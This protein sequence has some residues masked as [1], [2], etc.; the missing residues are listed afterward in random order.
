MTENAFIRQTIALTV[1][2]LKHWYR[3]KMQIFM[4]LIQPLIWLGLFGTMMSGTIG[5]VIPDFF[6]FLALGMVV[7]TALTTAMSSGMSLVWDRRFG[8]LDKL[9]AAPIPRGVIPL[10][11]VLATTV[12][13]VIQSAMVFVIALMLGLKVTGF[14]VWS[15]PIAILV[16]VGVTLIFSTIFV[17]F[18]MV[19]KSQ[20]VFMGINMLLMMPIMFVSG[21]MFPLSMM[22]NIEGALGAAL[23]VIAKYNPLTW[24]SD[25]MRMAFLSDS[26]LNPV[27]PMGE[28]ISM[29]SLPDLSI[30]VSILIL[31]ITAVFV[32]VLG[33]IISKRALVTK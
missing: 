5:S 25:A 30:G 18:G 33:M 15:I 3:D 24:A 10:S 14:G 19:I 9:R 4:A 26:A 6:T 8:F 13:A 11:R 1:R 2:E 32:T 31:M 29:L 20:E 23:T 28:P 16:I 17:T 21:A 12:K 22:G 7:I 27:G